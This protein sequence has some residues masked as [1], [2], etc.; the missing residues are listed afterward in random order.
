MSSLTNRE[1]RR[2]L[3]LSVIDVYIGLLTADPTDAGVTTAEVDWSGSTPYAR[4][5]A[6]FHAAVTD[7]AGHTT[8]RLNGLVTFAA[9]VDT[10]PTEVTHWGLFDASTGGNMRW[11]GRLK[12]RAGN[13]KTSIV[14]ADD[15]M[16][17]P[18]AGITLSL[19]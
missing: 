8:V 17:I 12:D 1:E 6:R 14:T 2:L 5:R 18:N 7:G 11:H 16:K 13:D 3:D 15:V 4:P 9:Y 10:T 19:A